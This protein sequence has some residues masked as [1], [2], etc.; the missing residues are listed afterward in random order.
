MDD[1]TAIQATIDRVRR[2]MPR[3]LDVMV[4]C[5]FAEGA[6]RRP[7]PDREVSGKFDKR[8]YQRELMR[9]RRKE[10]KA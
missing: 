10:G 5:N 7:A 3:N 1:L 8:S 6:L 2:A 4:L 9:R